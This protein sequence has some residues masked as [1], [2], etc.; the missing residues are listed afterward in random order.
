[1]VGYLLDFPAFPAADPLCFALG[2]FTLLHQLQRFT[3]T[4]L[5]LL[6]FNLV[7]ARHNRS[8]ITAALASLLFQTEFFLI[9]YISNAKPT[10]TLV[11]GR[12]R[13]SKWNAL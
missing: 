3:A 13:L 7:A 10:F 8:T 11:F 4:V 1:M 5:T 2:V 9:S 6:L 12:V